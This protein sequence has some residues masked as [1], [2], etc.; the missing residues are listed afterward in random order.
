MKRECRSELNHQLIAIVLL[1]MK[2]ID[3]NSSQQ[4]LHIY[5]MKTNWNAN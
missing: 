3:C 5:K 4:S 2:G 1:I